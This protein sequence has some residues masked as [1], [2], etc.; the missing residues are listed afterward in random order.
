MLQYTRDNKCT[1]HSV[2]AGLECP[3]DTAFQSGGRGALQGHLTTLYGFC[4]SLKDPC[5]DG[6]NPRGNL[7]QGSDGNFYGTTFSGGNVSPGLCGGLGFGCGTAFEISSSGQLTNIYTFC[8]RTN[9]SDGAYPDGLVQAT[10]GVFYGT[11]GNGG[12]SS[13]GVVFSGS[14]GLAA[15]IEALPNFGKVGRVIDILGNEL[16]GTTNVTFNGVP[17]AF[18][19]VSSTYIKAQVPSGATKVTTPSATISSN[20]PFQILP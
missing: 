4:S 14:K 7:T 5:P 19:V 16:A 10:N 18:K 8:S 15:F 11:T 3:R 9:C 6:T 13:W 20:V 2:F 1:E 12:S 17:A